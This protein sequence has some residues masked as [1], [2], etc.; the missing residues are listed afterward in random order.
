MDSD[1]KDIYGAHATFHVFKYLYRFLKQMFF[2][3]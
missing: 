3:L 1:I 2:Q